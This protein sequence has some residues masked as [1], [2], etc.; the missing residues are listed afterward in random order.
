MKE[1]VT[2]RKTPFPFPSHFLVDSIYRH[3]SCRLVKATNC[4]A[5]DVHGM[6]KIFQKKY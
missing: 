4:N 5:E 2:A 1:Q 6:K 3:K